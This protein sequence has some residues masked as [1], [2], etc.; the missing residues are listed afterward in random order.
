MENNDFGSF[1]DGLKKAEKELNKMTSNMTSQLEGN[2]EKIM[3]SQ[4]YDGEK[5]MRVNKKQATVYLAK[6]GSIKI[7]FD[8]ITDGKKFFEGK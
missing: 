6:D 2:F 3:N 8:D 1:L 7:V 4:M 5:K